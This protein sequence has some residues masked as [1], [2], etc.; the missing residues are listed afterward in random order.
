MMERAAG[1]ADA[2]DPDTLRVALSSDW[3]LAV[4]VSGEVASFVF[5]TVGFAACTLESPLTPDEADADADA[6]AGPWPIA[7]GYMGAFMVPL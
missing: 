5:A 2:A 6:D 4:L 3:V 7:L 1:C